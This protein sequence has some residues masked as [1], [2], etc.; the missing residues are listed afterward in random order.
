MLSASTG[1]DSATITVAGSGAV[2]TSLFTAPP[3]GIPALSLVRNAGKATSSA[4]RSALD[5]NG[6]SGLIY[7]QINADEASTIS[8]FPATTVTATALPAGPYYLAYYNGS[9]WVTVSGAAT[10]TSSASSGNTLKFGAV[11]FNPTILLAS[12]GSAY[13]CIY[14]GNVLPSPPPSAAPS[15]PPST[16]PSSS[17]SAGASASASASPSPSPSPSAHASASPSP[18]PGASASPAM[19]TDSTG[20]AMSVND[21]GNHTFTVTE[22]G[23]TGSYTVTSNND[24]V[25]TIPTSSITAVGSSPWTTTITY[26]A[27]SSGTAIVKVQD[28]NNQSVSVTVTVTTTPIT[29]QSH[30][31]GN[32][33]K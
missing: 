12:G 26:D 9:A 11:T 31:K 4:A 32:G 20:S 6:N 29:I 24:D 15:S 23:Y 18:S 5:A 17:P 16:A 2:S 19:L 27:I 14:A 21:T 3:T 7:V 22:T 10:D 13:F 33:T 30:S 1:N 25:I 8:G 28:A